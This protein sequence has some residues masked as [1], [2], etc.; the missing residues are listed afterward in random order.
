MTEHLFDVVLRNAPGKADERRVENLMKLEISAAP[1]MRSIMVAIANEPISTL[2]D[3]NPFVALSRVIAAMENVMNSGY[4][5]F[6]S[7]LLV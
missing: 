2:V 5:T 6:L 4:V 3:K 7:A 1:Q